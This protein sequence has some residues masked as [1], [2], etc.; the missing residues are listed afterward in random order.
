LTYALLFSRKRC[1]IRPAAYAIPRLEPEASSALELVRDLIADAFVNVG[2]HRFR[3]RIVAQHG[4]ATLGLID[5]TVL[6][7]LLYGDCDMLAG[8]SSI[9]TSMSR[10]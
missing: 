4:A 7:E 6:G 8:F 1:L 3:L 5:D 10:A 9:R 2:A